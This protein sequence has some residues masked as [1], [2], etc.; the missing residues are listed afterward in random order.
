VKSVPVTE[1]LVKI[2]REAMAREGFNPDSWLQYIAIN[3]S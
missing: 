1:A 2:A 3:K